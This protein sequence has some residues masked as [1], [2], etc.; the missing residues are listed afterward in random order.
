MAVNAVLKCTKKE[1]SSISLD[2]MYSDDK[3]ERIL[4][5]FA[6]STP[7][8][9]LQMTVDNPAAAEQFEPGKFYDV[10]FTPRAI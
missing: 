4:Q 5:G 9:H 8:A 3:G 7:Y 1:G 2:A 6:V 10:V